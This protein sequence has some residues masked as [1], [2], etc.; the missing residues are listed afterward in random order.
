MMLLYIIAYISY[1]KRTKFFI[2]MKKVE[3]ALK[4]ICQTKLATE[5]ILLY[6]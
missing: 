5:S 3:T 1:E 2:Q 6:V 4:H